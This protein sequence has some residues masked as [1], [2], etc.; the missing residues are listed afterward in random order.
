MP[1]AAFVPL[2]AAG[3]SVGAGEFQRRAQNKRSNQVMQGAQAASRPLQGLAANMG[4][5]GAPLVQQSGDYY[6]RLLRGDR[7]MLRSALAPERAEIT[8]IYRGAEQG[9][10][11]SG[12]RGA[13]RDVASGNL[14]RDR[15]GRLAA[16]AP[17]ARAGAAGQAGSLGL[18]ATNQAGS[19]YSNLLNGALGQQSQTLA[20]DQFHAGQ[21]EQFGSNVGQL[22]ID[23]TKAWQ[24]R[25]GGGGGTSYNPGGYSA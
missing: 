25:S 20:R 18:S 6:S 19:L 15:A 24:A 5:V 12:V 7:S 17:A 21:S 8:D 14:A 2:I 9:L 23:F 16:L 22:L 1:V 11:R 4:G 3:I 10:S 13:S